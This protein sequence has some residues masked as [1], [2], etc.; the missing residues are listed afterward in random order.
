[1]ELIDREQYNAEMEK[2]NAEKAAKQEK[3]PSAATVLFDD[4]DPSK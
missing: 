4:K 2:I 1:M 3:T